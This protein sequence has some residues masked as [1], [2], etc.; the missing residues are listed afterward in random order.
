MTSSTNFKTK[1]ARW[2]ATRVEKSKEAWHETVHV[3]YQMCIR[4]S[5]YTV[6]TSYMYII[7]QSIHYI[8]AAFQTYKNFFHSFLSFANLF[9]SSH[10]IPFFYNFRNYLV[11]YL[12]TF[13][14][15]CFLQFFP[16]TFSQSLLLSHVVNG[17]TNSVVFPQ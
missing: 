1:V 8:D 3:H 5:L 7:M 17:P 15:S 4:D 12:S 2:T 10:C 16:Q 13:L 14:F 6:S 11:L 9:A